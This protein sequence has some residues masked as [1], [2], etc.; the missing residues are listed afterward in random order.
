MDD[1]SSHFLSRNHHLSSE[2]S[3]FC[4]DRRSLASIAFGMRD[5]GT[6]RSA[7][8]PLPGASRQ[9]GDGGA[10]SSANEIDHLDVDGLNGLRE[11]GKWH[12]QHGS[13]A[14]QRKL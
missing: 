3:F 11:F 1:S 13:G 4:I 14:Q 12:E 7:F 2:R 6:D 8:G 5:R 9:D 10:A